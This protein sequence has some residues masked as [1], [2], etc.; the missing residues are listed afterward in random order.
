MRHESY[1]TRQDE[2][3]CFTKMVA[4]PDVLTCRAAL[5]ECLRHIHFS[6]RQSTTYQSMMSKF[7]SPS[8]FEH[9]ST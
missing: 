7:C 9:S 6:S 2:F 8:Y 5:F 1:P 4:L 3:G